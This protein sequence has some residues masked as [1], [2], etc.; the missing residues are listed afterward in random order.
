LEGRKIK[1]DFLTIKDLE[2]VMT[3]EYGQNTRNQ[4]RTL[5]NEGEMLLFQNQVTYY[6]FGKTGHHANECTSRRVNNP[7][8][9]NYRKFQGKCGTCRF[10]GH[11]TKD[12]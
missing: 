4:Q 12:R 3:E 1:G 10:C 5:D 2:R 6:S 11:K 8:S 7:N 9:K